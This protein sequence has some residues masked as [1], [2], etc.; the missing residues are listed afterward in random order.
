MLFMVIET[1]RD[2][3]PK[4][5]YRRF[6]DKG[7][8]LPEGL[9]YIDSW[10]AADLDRCFQVMECD[11]IALLQEWIAAWANLVAFEI[12]PIASDEQKTALLEA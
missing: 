3:N 6:R 2:G 12:V 8:M 5:V 1:F 10:L 9:T 7:R 4:P 11:D